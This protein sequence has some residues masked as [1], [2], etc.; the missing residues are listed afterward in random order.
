MGQ[1]KRWIVTGAHLF[2]FL[3]QPTDGR[4]R[5]TRR[6][7]FFFCLFFFVL[8][9][10]ICFAKLPSARIE[11][12]LIRTPYLPILGLAGVAMLM[13]GGTDASNLFG[14]AGIEWK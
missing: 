9:P 1:I 6:F 4:R 8:A 3:R 5:A 10:F 2:F 14:R 13:E 11:R 12:I 7:W